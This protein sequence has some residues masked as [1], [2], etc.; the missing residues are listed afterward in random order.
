MAKTL[1]VIRAA[2]DRDDE[3]IVA[4]EI[5]DL[6]IPGGRSLSLLASKLFVLLLD[7]AGTGVTEDRT[8]RATLESLNWG[9]RDLAEI[10]EAIYE[11]HGTSVTLFTETD[12]YSG[13]VLAEV[14]RPKN[15]GQGVMHWR[16]SRP[17]QQVIKDSRH[18]AAISGRAILAMECK[19]SPWLYQLCALHAGRDKISEDWDLYDL[20]ERLG[21]NARSFRRWNAFRE[22][23][24]EPACAEINQ[25]TG[26]GV[27]WEPV[28]FGRKVMGVRLSTWRKSAAE[29]SEADAELT[30]HRVGRKERRGDL[31]ERIVGERAARWRETEAKLAEL[32]ARRASAEAGADLRQIDLEAAIAAAGVPPLTPAQLRLGHDTAAELGVKLDI[33]AVYADWLR[34]LLQRKEPPHSPAG[35]WIDYCKRRG[36]GEKQ[37][38]P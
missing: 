7:R 12:I 13:P 32:N 26:I 19:Y 27:A 1:S 16:F 28:K 31:V 30:R 29:I 6:R 4:G 36:R 10:E 8:H 38:A 15:A 33:Q 37:D 22:R 21:A 14:R 9:K 17:F 5:V 35:H 2:A 24:L 34:T 3:V 20:R 11:L 25:L 18:W 23:V